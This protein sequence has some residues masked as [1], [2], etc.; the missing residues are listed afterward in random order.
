MTATRLFAH[1]PRQWQSNRYVYPV[2]SRRSRGLSIGVNL[3]PDKICNFDCVYCSVDRRSPGDQR[4]VD[5]AVLETELAAMLEHALGGGLWLEPPFDTTPAML[6]RVND[7]AFSGD[8][9]PTSCPQFA[10]ACALVARLVAPHPDVAAVVITNATLLDRPA[11]AAGLALLDQHRSA[12]WAKLDAGTD[13][14]YQ[15]IERTKVPLDRVL[16]QL[17]ACGRRRPLTIQ[18]LF[19]AYQGVA[20][21]DAEVD[22]WRDRLAWLLAQG[23]RIAQVQVYTTARATAEPGCVALPAERLEAI[24]DRA[25]ALGL[26]ATAYP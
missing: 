24:A 22:A 4:P 2:V 26:A 7:V 5:L 12:V 19:F 6:R 13:A 9:E 21:D 10:A 11:V 3:N 14:W 25:R 16:A 15:R 18:A 1:H 23:A 20:P 8:G 17:A